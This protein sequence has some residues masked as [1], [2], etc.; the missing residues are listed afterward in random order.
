MSASGIEN[1]RASRLARNARPETKQVLNKSPFALTLNR[2]VR[3]TFL[4]LDQ[5]LLILGV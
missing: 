2:K 4:E 1:C 5:F 3:E